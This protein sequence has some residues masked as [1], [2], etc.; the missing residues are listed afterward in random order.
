MIFFQAMVLLL[1]KLK[2]PQV[3]KKRSTWGFAL[4]VDDLPRNVD[5]G[6]FGAKNQQDG[7]LCGG[8]GGKGRA[9]ASAAPCHPPLAGVDVLV[10][11]NAQ[12]VDA[13]AAF[14]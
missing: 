11:D 3:A 4:L 12:F 7:L 8:N 13:C 6:V 9:R 5:L 1:L 2:K 10:D 14:R